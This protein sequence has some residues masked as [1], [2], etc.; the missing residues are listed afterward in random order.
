MAAT[1]FLFHPI[2]LLTLKPEPRD[3]GEGVTT[4]G[5]AARFCRSPSLIDNLRTLRLLPPRLLLLLLLRGSAYDAALRSLKDPLPVLALL[6][7]RDA[8]IDGRETSN[9]EEG[10]TLEFDWLRSRV[11]DCCCCLLVSTTSAAGLMLMLLLD[12]R[13]LCEFVSGKEGG[14]LGE[15]SAR[16]PTSDSSQRG[17][18]HTLSWVSLFMK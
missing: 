17:R 3:G 13:M 15:K 2:A 5:A 4:L 12:W 18:V 1:D 9:V 16:L 8:K 14:D 6:L 11:D 7:R 10:A